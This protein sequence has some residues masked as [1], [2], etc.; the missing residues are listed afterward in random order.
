MHLARARLP[1]A[2]GWE[3]AVSFAAERGWPSVICPSV[4]PSS[5]AAASSSALQLGLGLR[6]EVPSCAQPRSSPKSPRTCRSPALLGFENEF[7]LIAI[8]S[9]AISRRR[10]RSTAW[11]P[12]G[13]CPIFRS[14]VFGP[15]GFW[16]MTPLHYAANFAIW[17]PT[18][19]WKRR[20]T[21]DDDDDED[22]PFN[23]P[24]PPTPVLHPL[25]S[26]PLALDAETRR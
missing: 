11:L 3:R 12:D 6:D 1:G 16:T 19:R 18:A 4:R 15:S 14:Y 24:R 8:P 23:L 25:S 21:D 10:R 7:S 5:T 9:R 22:P 26:P 17:Q 13:Y 2:G 20:R